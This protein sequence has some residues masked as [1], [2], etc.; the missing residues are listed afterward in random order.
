VATSHHSHTYVTGCRM[1]SSRRISGGALSGRIYNRPIASIHSIR[2]WLRSLEPA[3]YGREGV[4]RP[5]CLS[6]Y[7]QD[8]HAVSGSVVVREIAFTPVNFLRDPSRLI[9]R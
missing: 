8:R 3:R 9:L 1:F 6:A 4:D 5:H 7:G 2:T